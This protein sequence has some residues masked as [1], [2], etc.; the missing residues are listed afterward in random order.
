MYRCDVYNPQI[1]VC[2][3]KKHISKELIQKPS[4]IHLLEYV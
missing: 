4:N 1:H 3:F 2:L